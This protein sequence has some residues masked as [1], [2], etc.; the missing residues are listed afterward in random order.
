MGGGAS[1]GPSGGQV[2]GFLALVPT[3]PS[4]PVLGQVSSEAPAA[5]ALGGRQ[6]WGREA[7]PKAGAPRARGSLPSQPVSTGQ[8][9]HCSEAQE[10]KQGWAWGS[11]PWWFF[12]ALDTTAWG[13]SLQSSGP[14]YPSQID[15]GWGGHRAPLWHQREIVLRGGP[16]LQTLA[17]RVH[18]SGP[19]TTGCLFTVENEAKPVDEGPGQLP[20]LEDSTGVEAQ[21]PFQGWQPLGQQQGRGLC[22][23]HTGTGTQVAALPLAPKRL[24]AQ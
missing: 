7:T 15:A 23:T 17:L 5:L 18:D 6:G 24:T 13:P 12:S 9:L 2:G 20:S 21:G 19:G 11:G 4:S 10:P 1:E 8:Q 14:V 22:L 16:S 3:S